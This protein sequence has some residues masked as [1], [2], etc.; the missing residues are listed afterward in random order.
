MANKIGHIRKQL[1]DR[2]EL[3]R[4]GEGRQTYKPR[5]TI[6]VLRGLMTNLKHDEFRPAL[7]I[8]FEKIGENTVEREYKAWQEAQH[9]LQ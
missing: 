6:G 8:I 2:G 5:T 9:H 7:R 3:V 4:D 1:E